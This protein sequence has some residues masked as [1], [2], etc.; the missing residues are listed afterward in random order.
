MSSL[1]DGRCSCRP[2]CGMNTTEFLVTAAQSPAILHQSQLRATHFGGIPPRAILNGIFW[3]FDQSA[4]TGNIP[5]LP[6]Q[7]DGKV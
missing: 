3:G 5:G 4:R 1:L 6:I 7:Y 2:L